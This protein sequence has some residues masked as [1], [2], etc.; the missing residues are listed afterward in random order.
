MPEK[1]R[2][3]I[4][5]L[6]MLA[7]LMGGVPVTA[8]DSGEQAMEVITQPL[9]DV[10][11]EPADET[12]AE[13]EEVLPTAEPTVEPTAEPTEEPVVESTAEPEA[14]SEQIGELEIVVME[15][16]GDTAEIVETPATSFKYSIKKGA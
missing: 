5:V 16:E 13:I 10:E 7:L 9:Y 15:A 6:L 3:I 12:T 2:R 4:A 1:M 11:A 8:E 14:E